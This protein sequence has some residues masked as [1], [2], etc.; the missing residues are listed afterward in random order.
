MEVISVTAI[1][2]KTAP[3]FLGSKWLGFL[4]SALGGS[5]FDSIPLKA[6]RFRCW[7]SFRKHYNSR[8]PSM[9][10]NIVISSVYSMSLPTGIPIAIRVTFNPCRFNCCD[11]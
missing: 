11:R 6:P 7:V 5:G 9:A 1:P 8:R 3:Y 10:F 4:T 2:L